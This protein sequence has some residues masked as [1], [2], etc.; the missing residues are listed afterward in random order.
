MKIG[1][2]VWSLFLID[3]RTDVRKVIG[4]KEL[5]KCSLEET[6]KRSS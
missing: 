6:G 2:I 3:G 1:S 5:G 4:S